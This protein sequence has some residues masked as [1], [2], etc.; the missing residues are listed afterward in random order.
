[1]KSKF[2]TLL[3]CLATSP[4]VWA[5]THHAA[6]SVAVSTKNAP[7]M[8]MQQV[9]VSLP[10]ATHLACKDFHDFIQVKQQIN[11]LDPHF[12][13]HNKSCT[14][15]GT[16]SIFPKQEKDGRI[17]FEKGLQYFVYQNNQLVVICLPGWTCKLW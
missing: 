17:H 11:A 12:D 14:M 5:N 9:N 6:A 10:A 13:W 8:T 15:I 4:F 16:Q 7:T 1:M 3:L 2:I